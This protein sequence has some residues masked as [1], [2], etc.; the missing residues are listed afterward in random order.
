MVTPVS[1]IGN[2][3]GFPIEV[4]A[5]TADRKEAAMPIQPPTRSD[6][7]TAAR[8]YGFT[9]GQQ[10]LAGFHDLVRTNLTRTAASPIS[11]SYPA[12]LAAGVTGPSRARRTIPS[13]LGTYAPLCAE[14]SPAPLCGRTV[15]VKDNIGISGV[16][17]S[18]GSKSLQG[19]VS[20]RGATVVERVLAAGAEI[21]AWPGR[22]RSSSRFPCRGTGTPCTC[23]T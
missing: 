6:V 20:A 16:P 1:R 21:T 17:M 11:M 15:A 10:D 5:E 18:N 19:H 12:F 4:G 14:R 22:A 8:H 3:S 2:T 7:E 13:V 23:G 9:L